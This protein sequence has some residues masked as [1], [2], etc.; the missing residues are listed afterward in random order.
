MTSTR[1]ALALHLLLHPRTGWGAIAAR[2][3]TA[4]GL[5]AGL[6]LPGSLTSALAVIAGITWFNRDWHAHFGYSAPAS[7]AL[8]IGLA[9]LTLSVIY[10]L[11]LA[12]VFT[13]IGRMY[14]SRG[15]YTQA[16]A[17]AAYGTVP[18]WIGGAFMFLLPAALPGMLAFV[19][20]CLLYSHGAHTLL[21]VAEAE[22]TE[23]VAIALLL[24]AIA[25]TLFGM[26]ASALHLL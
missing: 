23:F 18:V 15:G 26:V 4:G 21:N 11:V 3:H 25:M 5:V 13:G 19:Y 2:R 16:L 9:T 22:A 24:A 12:A 6:I 10:A 17:L 1:Y 14:S 7:Q 20:A 8:P